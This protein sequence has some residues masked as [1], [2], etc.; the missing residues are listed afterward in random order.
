[1]Y[2]SPIRPFIDPGFPPNPSRKTP[3]NA[4]IESVPEKLLIPPLFPKYAIKS[5]KNDPQDLGEFS[6]FGLLVPVYVQI[7]PQKRMVAV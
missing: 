5:L 6:F 2:A 7:G 1:M 3:Q 4:R